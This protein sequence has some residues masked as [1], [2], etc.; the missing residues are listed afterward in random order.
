M[1]REYFS[2]EPHLWGSE[3]N[4]TNKKSLARFIIGQKENLI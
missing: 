3:M 1:G 4:I 2:N